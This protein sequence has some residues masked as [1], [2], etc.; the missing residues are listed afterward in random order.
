MKR[1]L[2]ILSLLAISY[3]VF[4]QEGEPGDSVRISFS[5]HK[6]FGDFLIDT[7]L[8]KTP[9][10]PKFGLESMLGP[11][12][13]KDYNQYFQLDNR[14]I[15]TQGSVQMPFYSITYP[16]LSWH[17]TEQLQ[18]GTFQLN[19][20]IRL[21]TYGQ[22]DADG[23]KVPNRSAMP[24]QRNN[25]VGGMELKTSNGFGI[26]IDVRRGHDPGFPY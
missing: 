17:S 12:M 16:G 23:Y 25:F 11:D 6:P 14:M 9:K 5:N 4:A 22:Y 1:L 8:L 24:W 21:H 18:M 3:T 13:S 15:F 2:F 20:N 10:L 19:D 7:N 26:R